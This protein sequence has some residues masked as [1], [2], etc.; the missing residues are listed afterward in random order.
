M[1]CSYCKKDMGDSDICPH[2]GMGRRIDYELFKSDKQE[3]ERN[4]DDYEADY[5]NRLE[6]KD[7]PNNE[8]NSTPKSNN[9]Y[10]PKVG[11]TYPQKESTGQKAVGYGIAIAIVI[12]LGILTGALMRAGSP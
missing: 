3:R 8:D 12:G 1:D 10:S 7:N 9:G 5:L 2:C 4:F 6:N 11:R